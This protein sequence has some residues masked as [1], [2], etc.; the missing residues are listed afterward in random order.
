MVIRNIDALGRICLPISYRKL[1]NL[2][3]DD[4]TEL[5]LDGEEIIIRK[6]ET[7]TSEMQL[8]KL[9]EDLCNQS[10]SDQEK[11]HELF[12]QIQGIINTKK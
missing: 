12:S 5:I 8:H 6:H 1:L 10:P 2:S 4:P 3:A 9:E 11:L 7:K